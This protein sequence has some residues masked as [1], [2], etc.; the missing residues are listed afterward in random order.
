MIARQRETREASLDSC[1]PQLQAVQKCESCASVG[2]GD[3]TVDR[4]MRRSAPKLHTTTHAFDCSAPS[5]ATACV[6]WIC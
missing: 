5:R 2:G 4:G 1:L 3:A 6:Q